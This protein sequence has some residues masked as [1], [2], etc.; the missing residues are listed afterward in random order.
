M[1]T[2]STSGGCNILIRVRA[3]DIGPQILYFTFEELEERLTDVRFGQ[4][5]V[6]WLGKKMTQQS[7]ALVGSNRHP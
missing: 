2:R 1:P 7:S 3:C 6:K 5:R 4:V